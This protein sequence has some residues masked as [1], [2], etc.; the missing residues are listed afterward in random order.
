VPAGFSWMNDARTKALQGPFTDALAWLH[1]AAG[2][3]LAADA[4]FVLAFRKLA[5]GAAPDRSPPPERRVTNV[6]R[7]CGELS[8]CAPPSPPPARWICP[9]CGK[10]NPFGRP[11]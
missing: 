4:N 1:R 11:R 8:V 9:W 2:I 3:D 7:E 5:S 6:C 10:P